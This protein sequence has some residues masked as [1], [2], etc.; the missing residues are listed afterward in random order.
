MND[1][2]PP[3]AWQEAMVEHL[4][5][6]VVDDLSGVRDGDRCVGE[7]PSARYYLASLA[8]QDLDLGT[9]GARR[10]RETPSALGFEFEV[11]A[12]GACRL[13]VEASAS[14]YYRVWPTLAEQ[15]AFH[16]GQ[17][18][19]AE[20]AKRQY[21]LAPV[22]QRVDVAVGP[23]EIALDD[24]AV[25]QDVARDLF[26]EEF[27]R[28]TAVAAADPRV[29][30]RVG[31]ERRER[32]VPGSE[33][34]DELSFAAW[35]DALGGEPVKPEWSA[36][37]TLLVRR[38]AA[39]RRVVATLENLSTDPTVEVQGRGR[40]QGRRRHDDAR[41]H[42]LFRA[43]L[44]FSAPAG[45]LR[46]IRI[47][48]G[49]D[50]YRYD[51]DLPAY[52]TNCGIVGIEDADQRLV[53]LQSVPSPV[54]STFRSRP[55]PHPATRFSELA[56]DPIP[57]LSGLARDLADYADH[58]AW[59]EPLNIPDGQAAGAQREQDRRAVYAEADRFADG[60]RWL[61]TDARLLLA[62]KLA[63]RTMAVAAGGGPTAGWRLFQ[64]VFIVSQLSALAWREHPR[65]SFTPGL[66]GGDDGRDPTATATVVF[67]PTG[68][69]KT[70][71]YLG[72]IACALFYDRA[73]GK[74]HGVTS[75][76]RFPLRLLTLQQ[77]QRHLKV[78]AVADS[79]RRRHEADL[80]AVG[81]SAGTPF[82]VGFFAGERNTPNSL[83]RDP[84]RLN[85]LREDSEARRGVQVIDTCPYCDRKTVEVERPDSD[86][87]R[88]FHRCTGCNRRIPLIV[89]DSEIYRYPP[90]VLVGT[91]DKLANIGLSD[92]FGALLGDVDCY[93][94]Q[95]GYGRGGKCH[96]RNRPGHAKDP[97]HPLPH[98]WHDPSP[99]LEIVDELHLVNEELGAFS[100]HYEGLLAEIQQE[101]SRRSRPDGRGVRMKVVA[102]T[103]TIRGEDRQCDHLFDLPS[104][105]TP[106][107]GP[108]L[109]DSFYRETLLDRPMRR[110]VGVMPGR[111]TAE[112][113]MVRIL[114]ALHRAI[115]RLQAG[116]NLPASL[117]AVPDAERQN[118]INLYRTSLSYVT[119]RV[120]F[121]KLRRS[122]DTQVNLTLTREG[123]TGLSVRQL[124]GDE[125][126]DRVRETLDD[127]ERSDGEIDA[128]VATS[129]VSHGVD[130]DRLNLMIFNGMPRSMAEYIQA[131]SRVGRRRL[132]LVF[133]VYN[134]VRERDRS[135]FRYHGKFH[136]YLDR[137]VE[138]IAINRWSRFAARRTLPGMLMGEILQ[139]GNRDW[140]D[141]GRTGHLHDLSRMQQALRPPDAGGI[142]AVEPA[143]MLDALGRAYQ[144]GADEA[145]ELADEIDDRIPFALTNIAN[146][147][148]AGAPAGGSQYRATGDFL[149]LE[150]EP[151]MSLRDISEGLPFFTLQERKRS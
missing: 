39:G 29:E 6:E 21:R 51:A 147:G 2:E 92:R 101:L 7:P 123:R 87:L 14:C 77:T 75:W 30:R 127:L 129:M 74:T 125:P 132:G 69:G 93:C 41:D 106:Q 22:F 104:I 65:E 115:R 40:S 81:G 145:E 68:G 116:E 99:S 61:E 64:L 80:Q 66:W 151:M 112:M 18:S 85:R 119:S 12:S 150:F 86:E 13:T 53:R 15:L 94:P 107:P 67:Y 56:D 103:A 78:V 45:I 138:P 34:V 10:G 130:V 24:R 70:E 148:A 48:L 118:L 55:R 60:V 1:F 109:H 3:V 100:G 128:V 8:P 47:D 46:P 31:D 96:E 57:L 90:A 73:R 35:L 19:F 144:K 143:A 141:A 108:T 49:P 98:R 149:G 83:S 25:I 131:S 54:H 114:V 79:L 111:A 89:V 59:Q 97:V 71:A 44:V 88:L 133:L 120:D 43:G 37:I 27:T 16:G 62:F 117:A 95:H 63:N 50:A 76:S 36:A 136:E 82:A 28:V 58:P 140:W 4:Q 23:V 146:A 113:V 42:F 124:T 122:L 110:F 105:V 20:R 9:G 32:Y 38:T 52:A 137:M 72:L 134:P 33:L 139:V 142:P 17:D 121:G 84:A 5:R 102:T 26:A 126:F 91:L 11:P 135:H